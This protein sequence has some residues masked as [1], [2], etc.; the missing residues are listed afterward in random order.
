[1]WTCAPGWPPIDPTSKAP[2][3]EA[4]AISRPARRARNDAFGPHVPNSNNAKVAIGGVHVGQR[5]RIGFLQV[6]VPSG[7]GPRCERIDRRAQRDARRRGRSERLRLH[8]RL[9]RRSVGNATAGCIQHH[10]GRTGHAG[11]LCES[12]AVTGQAQCAA[13]SR[14]ADDVDAVARAGARVNREIGVAVRIRRAG[15]HDDI[16]AR[17]RLQSDARVLAERDDRQQLAGGQPADNER[18]RAILLRQAAADGQEECAASSNCSSAAPMPAIS[19]AKV[20]E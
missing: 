14:R 19:R 17:T 1:M 5:H 8:A 13:E 20:L 10:A 4:S 18:R 7:R 9:G 2:V 3:V 15:Q 16:A 11:R 6:D 12:D